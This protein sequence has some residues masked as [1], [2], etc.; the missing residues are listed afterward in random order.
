MILFNKQT[1]PG[2]F[3][4]VGMLLLMVILQLLGQKLFRYQ[5]DWLHSGHY[6]RLLSAHW[7]HTGWIHFLLNAVGLILC[8]FIATPYWSVRRWLSYQII[9]GLGISFLFTLFNP[10]LQWYLGYS[11]VLYGIFLLAAIDLFPRDR[12]VGLLL[13]AAIVIK[14][15]LEQT[16]DINL[17]SSDIIGSPV[18]VDAH[19]YGVLLAMAIALLNH[20][21]TM[22]KPK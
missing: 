20:I 3:F 15:T 21:F 14:I 18:I 11:G 12:L 16:S 9:L 22:L 10:E 7:A 6:W 2:W 1:K 13:G 19:L 5:F 8:M 4:V 17:T